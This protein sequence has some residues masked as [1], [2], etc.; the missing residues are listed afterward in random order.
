MGCLFDA[1]LAV[2]WSSSRTPGPANPTRDAT[3]VGER[4]APDVTLSGFSRVWPFETGF[5]PK[6]T[7]EEG[8]FVLHV[9]IWPG[10]VPDP[11]DALVRIRD[12]AQVR[13]MVCWLSTLDE[14]GELGV[15]FDT[16]DVLP[17]EA[18]ASCVSEEGW[19][20]GGGRN[21]S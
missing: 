2:D 12:Q 14:R 5:T 9:E 18:V 19:I 11:L 20:V 17:P 21:G 4:A 3:W 1:Y 6:P 13:A 10:V 8:P 7:A 16:P 15:L